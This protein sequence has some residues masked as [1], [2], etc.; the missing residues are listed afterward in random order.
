MAQD[1]RS[2]A[3]SDGR[4]AIGSEKYRTG[5]TDFVYRTRSFERRS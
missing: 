3:E 5:V 4:L 2:P 1:R